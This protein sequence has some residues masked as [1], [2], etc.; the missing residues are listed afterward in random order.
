MGTRTYGQILD[1]AW[2]KVN[3]QTGGLAVRWPEAEGIRWLNNA[4]L[5][6]V[7]QFPAANTKAAVPTLVND[8]RQTLAGLGLT[9][10]LQFIDVVCAM[11]TNGTT[12]GR[13][14]R[15]AE[16]A[17]L[18]DNLPS[19]HTVTAEQPTT[20]CHDPRDPK[21][22]YIY[23]RPTLF[24]KAEVLYAAVPTDQD[25]L[26]DTWQLDDVYS[27][28]AEA[29]VLYSFYSKDAAYTN[30]PQ[31]AAGFWTLFLQMLGIR[32]QNLAGMAGVGDRKATGT[33]GAS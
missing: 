14:I 31:L 15:K 18:D 25:A 29:F 12:R 3:E 1:G 23:P 2:I 4:A 20:W 24:T 21:A 9:D 13:P 33:V 22:F 7:N 19:W 5:E 27:N 30:N 26:T 8:S 10:G 17:W 32:G 28:A 16:R 6:I 11:A